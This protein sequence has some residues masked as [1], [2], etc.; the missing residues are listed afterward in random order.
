MSAITTKLPR[1]AGGHEQADE[2][3]RDVRNGAPIADRPVAVK[4]NQ[5]PP[6]VTRPRYL[7]PSSFDTLWRART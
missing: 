5:V 1:V 3:V 7:E 6:E 4:G 2:S